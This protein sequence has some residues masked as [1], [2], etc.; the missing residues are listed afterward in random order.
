MFGTTAT[1]VN[2]DYCFSVIIA[3]PTT[4]YTRGI[5]NLGCVRVRYGRLERRNVWMVE[6][7]NYKLA[8]D[9]AQQ[10]LVLPVLKQA[11]GV[12]HGAD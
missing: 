11:Y 2:R 12:N 3:F 4:P 7:S 1:S 5:T 6:V 9:I 10:M 8:A